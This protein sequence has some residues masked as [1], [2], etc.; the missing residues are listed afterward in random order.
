MKLFLIGWTDKDFGFYDVAVK[1]KEAGHQI[2]YWSAFNIFKDIKTSE[3]P[4]TIFMIL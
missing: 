4:E 2:I 3:F 1:L